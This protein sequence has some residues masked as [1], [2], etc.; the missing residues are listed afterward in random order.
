MKRFFFMAAAILAV[1]A[2]T[3]EPIIPEEP[4]EKQ[5]GPIEITLVAGAPETRT[6][7]YKDGSLKP[8]WSAGD[9]ISVV[10]VPN[11][12]NEENFETVFN[13]EIDDDLFV[14]HSFVGDV[15]PS[16][17]R[18]LTARFSGAVDQLGQYR[19]LY[20]EHT[21]EIVTYEYEDWYGNPQT[22]TF[23]EESGP[24][25]DWW[26]ESPIVRFRIPSIQYPS[27]TSFDPSADLLV[28]APFNVSD[29]G[30]YNLG[31]T[32]GD[33]PISFTRVNAIAKLKFSVTGELTGKMEGEKVR[34]V[35]FG[36]WG[37]IE[38]K[39]APKTRSIYVDN[40]DNTHGLTGDMYYFLSLIDDL[41]G[42]DVNEDD[43]LVLPDA[44]YD[45]ATAQYSDETAYPILSTDTETATYLIVAPSI[46]KNTEYEYDD[47]VEVFG[48]PILV[49][50]D[51]YVIRR[52]ITLSSS[53]IALQP[54]V[55]TTLN[56]SL[57]ESNA[58]VA[59]KSISFDPAETTLI[60][61]DGEYVDL[62]AIEISF[63]GYEI[64]SSDHPQ[65]TF[66]KYFTVTAPQGISL[67]YVSYP[68]DEGY[69]YYTDID[70]EEISHLY[71][72]VD[73][74][75]QPG[76]YVVQVSYGGCTATCT[77]HVIN[78]SDSPF[79]Q[80][81]DTAVEAICAGAWGGRRQEGKIT[82]YEASKVTTLSNPNNGYK[83]Y[84]YGNTEITSFNEFQHFTGLTWLDQDAFD[85]C[86]NLQ[87]IK[88]PK[89]LVMI[90]Y[91]YSGAAAFRYCAN[92]VSVDLSA[93]TDLESI[94]EY[95]FYGCTKL[96][97]ITL[98]KSVRYIAQNAFNS[99]QGL[100]TVT[101]PSD[102]QLYAIYDHAFDYCRHLSTITLPSSLETIGVNA[103][104]DCVALASINIP[105]G[106]T[107]ISDYAFYNCE[108][109]N[110]V[111]VP[112]QG[113]F[114]IGEGAFEYSGLT[115]IDNLLQHAT[116]VDRAAFDH[117]DVQ[118]VVIPSTMTEIPTCFLSYCE[119]LESVTFASPCHVTRI[120]NSAFGFSGLT[121]IV[122][123]NSLTYLG[124]DVFTECTNLVSATIPEGI[125]DISGG[126]F[127]ECTSLSSVSIPESVKTIGS[128][129][130]SKCE[131]L[132]HLVIPGKLT[133]IGEQAFGY[134]GLKSIEF[135]FDETAS[136]VSIGQS[137]FYMCTQLESIWLPDCLK[138]ISS[139]AF[140]GCT[141]LRSVHLP[142]QLTMI[143]SPA[144]ADCTSLRS[145]EFP[146]SLT[147]LYDAF[148]NV[149]FRS[150]NGETG[151][152]F[153][154]STPPSTVYSV[155][156]G[157]HWDG[158]DWVPGVEI[159]VPS[160]SESAY[161][162][163]ANILNTN[164]IIVGF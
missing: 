121:S 30:G 81:A 157:E 153:N 115:N 32:N 150:G 109:L 119:D 154:G 106:V 161:S 9:N 149:T 63:P 21:G 64:G 34:K 144:F 116:G 58:E 24:S 139:Y 96:A 50:T 85:S 156:N 31:A 26:G 10:R 93:C 56:I 102:S 74:S 131:S 65:E 20:P 133:S 164:N 113:Q 107:Y 111:Q 33:I 108:S 145:I 29:G 122:L 55:V 128:K 146:A 126:L 110:T 27:A 39:K 62:K 97:S 75:M 36:G 84:F 112:A 91:G 46:M 15:T 78:L 68:E 3:R 4:E 11:I 98:P 40:N 70:S 77:V 140:Y 138:A 123:P 19:A 54:S 7:V 160:G 136:S 23:Y 60:P 158:T 87:S 95:T 6:E 88:L 117:T 86:T 130:F 129:A 83:S 25:L 163:V 94:S 42:F 82:Y 76:D 143:S 73:S 51:H 152:K 66:Y 104:A 135:D 103:F 49:E 120:N 1:V 67:R 47:E 142:N 69:E 118:S 125:T 141:A 114:S 100:T 148:R 99:C 38:K 134:S 44:W 71:L 105:E 41:D 8:Y 101:I 35:I 28:S 72:S 45:T 89:S 17:T 61:G 22:D 79:I 14:Y 80:F 13:S 57:S 132:E 137:A 147:T 162:S 159:Q 127:W 43:G 2:C 52:L 59:D 12:E 151:V 37:A 90:N 124:T 92:L 18:S 5:N 16:Q 48:L 155:I 53:G